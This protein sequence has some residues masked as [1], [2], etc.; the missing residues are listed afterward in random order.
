LPIPNGQDPDSECDNEGAASCGKTGV[1]NGKGACQVYPSGTV[2]ATP[3]CAPPG[4]LFSPLCD[5]AQKCV[6]VSSSCFP[7]AC[8][9]NS[10]CASSCVDDT[11][12]AA[13]A[14][15]DKNSGLCV[16]DLAGGS[17]CTSSGQCTSGFCVDGVCCKT[18]C[19]GLCAACSAAAKAS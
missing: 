13:A 3:T 7:F 16:P 9:S 4:N 11:S 6:S 8:A 15:C 19:N 12:C 18:I 2:C 1:C 10:A 17:P 14:F 5:G